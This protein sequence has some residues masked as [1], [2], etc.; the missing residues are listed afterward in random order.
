MEA[1]LGSLFCDLLIQHRTCGRHINQVCT[2]FCT[3][4]DISFVEVYFFYV[5]RE[6]YDRDNRIA[7]FHTVCDRLVENAPS[8]ITSSTLDL[9]LA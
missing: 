6:S 1:S 9:V 2:F 5:N 3:V 8:L 4:Q 7:V